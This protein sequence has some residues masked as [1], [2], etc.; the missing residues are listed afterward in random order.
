MM[1]ELLIPRPWWRIREEPFSW[2]YDNELQIPRALSIVLS[3]LPQVWEGHLKWLTSIQFPSSETCSRSSLL[4]GRMNCVH[5]GWGFVLR[6]YA[7]VH[8]NQP[9]A[10]WSTFFYAP[11]GSVQNNAWI[12][13]SDCPPNQLNKWNCAFLPTTN[14]TLPS[15]ITSC[16]HS[17]CNEFSNTW[18]S[19]LLTSADEA[20][21]FESPQRDRIMSHGLQPVT[22]LQR[23]LSDHISLPPFLHSHPQHFAPNISLDNDILMTDSA[24][25]LFTLAFILRLN[26][27]YRSRVGKVL[28]HFDGQEDVQ[29]AL[30][31]QGK[32]EGKD[33][34]C[35]AA[36]IR[37]GDR[38]IVGADPLEYCRN[39]TLGLPC[40][41]SSG[42]LGPCDQH[43][44]CGE[45][46]PFSTIGLRHVLE[47]VSG[48]AASAVIPAAAAKT[49][50]LF[51]DDEDWLR[52]EIFLHRNDNV[53]C[54]FAF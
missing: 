21:Q 1:D 22:D 25:V 12:S 24:A 34:Q 42:K 51:S 15:V 30:A 39:L 48:L 37:R 45:G 27:F 9:Y 14:C 11:E 32:S 47:K 28:F 5:P 49:V 8:R 35:V 10:I 6:S 4:V 2:Q 17:S 53:S 36:H 41:D 46:A 29:T 26:A 33:L 16:T 52:K 43:M 54:L 19:S 7:E 20:G 3:R 13:E 38:L 31:S 23:T 40:L 44:G 50:I 18:L